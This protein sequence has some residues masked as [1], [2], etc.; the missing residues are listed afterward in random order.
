MNR[1]RFTYCLGELEQNRLWECLQSHFD[2]GSSIWKPLW[3][4]GLKLGSLNEKW[5]ERVRLDWTESITEMPEGIHLHTDGWLAMGDSLQH[6]AQGW[7]QFGYLSGWRNEQ[8]DVN[9]SEGRPLFTLERSAFR[10]LGLLSRAVH[11]NGLTEYEGEWVFWI[12]RRSP[13]KAVDPNKLDNLVGGGIASGESIRE[14]MLREGMEEAGLDEALLQN[15]SGQSRRRSCRPVSRG[16]HNEELF[17]FDIVLPPDVLPE[18]QDGEVAEFRRMR[19]PELTEAMCSGLLMNDA[20]LA[21]LDAFNRYGL[22]DRQHPLAV[23]LDE[24]R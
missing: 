3:L 8:F 6:M 19:I 18:N 17:I 20:F 24:N 12:G 9:D 1:P 13:Y 4:N 14:A 5:L 16:L 2:W 21:T 7:K 22:L 15:L 23:W 10:P 11:I